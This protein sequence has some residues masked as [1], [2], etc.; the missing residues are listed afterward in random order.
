LDNSI[1]ILL[2]ILLADLYF[3]LSSFGALVIESINLCSQN[4]TSVQSF[5]GLFIASVIQSLYKTITSFNSKLIHLSFI[6]FEISF[7]IPRATH[8]DLIL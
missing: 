4:I 8:P 1:V 6:N 5:L 2:K 7:I 3:Q